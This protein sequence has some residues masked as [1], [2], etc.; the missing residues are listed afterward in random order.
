MDGRTHTYTDI[1]HTEHMYTHA[2][3]D[4][5]THTHIESHYTNPAYLSI[6]R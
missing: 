2:H 4:E 6:A 3:T 1:T 5:Q